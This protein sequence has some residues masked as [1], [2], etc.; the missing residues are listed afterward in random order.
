MPR[1]RCGWSSRR[2]DANRRRVK[3]LLQTAPAQAF[4]AWAAA[5]Y[6]GLV[7]RSLRWRIEGEAPFHNLAKGAPLIIVFWHE[8]LPAMP[9]LW[10]RLM[11]LGHARPAVV[12]ASQHRDGQLIGRAVGHLGI[13]LVSGSTSRGGAAGL[14]GLMRALQAGMHAGITPD[15]PRGPRRT[16]A[17]GAAQLAALSG[18]QV[19]PCGAV[20]RPAKTLRSWDAMQFPL[21]FGR[22]ALVYGPPIAV[23][24][25]GWEASVPVI[26]AALNATMDRAAALL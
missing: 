8:T 18:R 6:V 2:A 3:K 10:L 16:C 12:L 13:G 26:T 23:P 14:R 1:R 11:R 9:I 21:P 24:R 15:G 19:L 25:A 17:P 7:A 5:R 4:I 22:G 20:I